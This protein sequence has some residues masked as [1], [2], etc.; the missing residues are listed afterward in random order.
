MGSTAKM[1][2]RYECDK[3][4]AM[5]KYIRIQSLCCAMLLAPAMSDSALAAGP[6]GLL[7]DTGITDCWNDSAKVTTGV[8]VDPGSHPR[9]D[10]RYG[11]DVAGM[12]KVGGGGKGFD[13]TK[14][15]NNGTALPDAALMAM[16]VKNSAFIRDTVTSPNWK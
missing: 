16:R 3:G 14:I 6:T 9:Q 10:C 1:S 13:F 4:V 7:Y 8:E 11:R 5:H 2:H 15:A 12:R